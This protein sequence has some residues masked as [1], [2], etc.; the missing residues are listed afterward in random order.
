MNP[1]EPNT[2]AW[3]SGNARRTRALGVLCWALLLG[4]CNGTTPARS[5]SIPTQLQQRQ[6]ALAVP[7]H[8]QDDYWSLSLGHYLKPA[9]LTSYWNTASDQRFS[10][11]G[12]RWLEF[13]LR[14]DMLTR[15][16][17]QLT[18]KELERLRA[19]PGFDASLRLLPQTLERMP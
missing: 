15:W 14:E 18:P 1:I 12:A 10:H 6:L 16:R 7:P 11:F 9:E 2:A 5:E 8:S 19:A 17:D 3:N 13:C 4:A